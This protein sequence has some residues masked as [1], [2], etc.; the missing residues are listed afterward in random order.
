MPYQPCGSEPVVLT[1]R[2]KA[3]AESPQ[4]P[5]PPAPSGRGLSLPRTALT[6]VLVRARARHRALLLSRLHCDAR[7]TCRAPLYGKR[8]CALAGVFSPNPDTPGASPPLEPPTGLFERQLSRSSPYCSAFPPRKKRQ[9]R[10][11][12]GCLPMDFWVG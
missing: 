7:H 1:P 10:A 3:G 6:R 11:E 2:Q 4:T 12:L 8:I 5:S 9:P